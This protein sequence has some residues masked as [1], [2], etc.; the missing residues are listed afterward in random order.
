M[1][2]RAWWNRLTGGDAD[3]LEREEDALRNRD[4]GEPPA[5][6]EDYEGIKDDVTTREYEGPGADA[7]DDDEAFR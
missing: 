3:R 4:P 2:L 7:A 6:L 1:S 5:Q